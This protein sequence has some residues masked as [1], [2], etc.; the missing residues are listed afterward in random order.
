MSLKDDLRSR[1][2]ET[3]EPE[4]STGSRLSVK[5]PLRI[6]LEK[7]MLWGSELVIHCSSV[8]D[9]LEQLQP[10]HDMGLLDTRK[11]D[12]S[13]KRRGGLLK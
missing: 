5:V 9:F 4:R 10:W 11:S 12:P 8:D 1:S 13:Q 3:E 6:D 7:G 2:S